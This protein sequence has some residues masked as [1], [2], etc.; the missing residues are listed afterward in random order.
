MYRE[1]LVP[2]FLLLMF[3]LAS[4]LRMYQ[5]SKA[6]SNIYAVSYSILS[7]IYRGCFVLRFSTS[8][9]LLMNLFSFFKRKG[10]KKKATEQ[11]T[12]SHIYAVNYMVLSLTLFYHEY[13]HS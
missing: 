3:F 8:F 2:S 4:T 6:L 13:L 7:I 5:L 12:L 1:R 9:L 10:K 11:N